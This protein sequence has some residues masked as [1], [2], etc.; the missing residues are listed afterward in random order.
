M[1]R[2][3]VP[4][5]NVVARWEWTGE[6][7]SY[8]VPE[9][10][11][12]TYPIT[13]ASDGELYASSGDP[14][15]GGSIW[16]LDIEKF[17]GM[18]PDYVISKVND[19]VDFTGWGGWG[20]K[21]SGMISVKDVLYLAV[22]NLGG[23]KPPVY[24]DKS[25]NGTDA[26]I[27]ASRD[28]GRTWEPDVQRL[29]PANVMFKG[30]SFGGPAFINFGKNNADARDEFVYAVSSDQWDNG[31][32]LTLGRVHQERILEA[33]AW[34][35][36]AQVDDQSGPEWTSDLNKAHAVLCEDRFIGLPEMVY[37]KAINRFLLLT[38]K[39]NEDFSPKDGSRLIVYDAPH[40]WG[41]FTLVHYEERWESAKMNPYSPRIPL[42][43]MVADGLSGWL[44]FSGSW[45]DDEGKVDYRS[46]VRPFRL[47]LK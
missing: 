24:G 30:P 3:L 40:P 31:S 20:A 46:H 25:Q 23:K 5:S 1:R 26:H 14:G 27:F 15:W 22:Q 39:F 45:S 18:A 7:I 19:M 2:F 42:K 47:L 4:R 38:W 29:F 28:L 8:P 16:G 12:D 17:S 9:V 36:V 41:P 43:W 44:Q 11:G 33:D 21:P 6:Q 10:K 35:W 32:R 13:W 37:V 34:Q